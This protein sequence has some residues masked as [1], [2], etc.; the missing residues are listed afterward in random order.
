MAG[1]DGIGTNDD[2]FAIARRHASS[3]EGAISDATPPRKCARRSDPALQDN[4]VAAL[5]WAPTSGAMTAAA[6][7]NPS[8]AGDKRA[9]PMG[10]PLTPFAELRTA[11]QLDDAIARERGFLESLGR[12]APPSERETH[13]R[14]LATLEKA[15]EGGGT[16]TQRLNAREQKVMEDLRAE[17]ADLGDTTG[18]KA[19]DTVRS[20]LERRDCLMAQRVAENEKREGSRSSMG[21][22]GHAGSRDEVERYE[23]EQW[24]RAVNP[25]S[26]AGVVFAA[27]AAARGGSV[28]DVRAAG[29]AGNVVEVVAGGVGHALNGS[30]VRVD[31]QRPRGMRSPSGPPRARARA[32]H[33]PTQRQVTQKPQSKAGTV[34]LDETHIFQGEVKYGTTGVARAV[35]YHWEGPPRVNPNARIVQ[36]TRTAADR[37]GVYRGAV[38]VRDARTGA[39]IRKADRSTFFPECYSEADVRHAIHEAHASSATGSKGAW[40]GKTLQGLKIRGW[41]DAGGVIV[42]A[43]PVM[44]EK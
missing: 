33:A 3:T 14:Y 41:V 44:E 35:G 19:D 7:S 30:R 34:T 24:I 21:L 28:E 5:P 29:E 36:E 22:D 32:D 1:P 8:L 31:D 6:L 39:W 43:Y 13:Q 16:A 26:G 2:P 38:E 10:P 9:A 4:V 18:C 23:A 37:N 42:T 17:L 15:R 11:S 40:E 27:I 25:G 20:L 12:W